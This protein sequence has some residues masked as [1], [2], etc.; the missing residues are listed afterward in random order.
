[1]TLFKGYS[2]PSPGGCKQYTEG[3]MAPEDGGSTV[4]AEIAV[5]GLD[6]QDLGF[7]PDESTTSGWSHDHV[8]LNSLLFCFS[9]FKV[10]QTTSVSK[11]Q[12]NSL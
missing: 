2:E 12:L 7:S 11:A 10:C 9:E 8:N 3:F 1:M 6:P 5:N 4:T